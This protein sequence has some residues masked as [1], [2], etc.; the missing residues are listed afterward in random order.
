MVSQGN[1][2]LSPV[3]GIDGTVVGMLVMRAGAGAAVLPASF[4]GQGVQINDQASVVTPEPEY[5]LG[6]AH[7]LL[8]I[9]GIVVFAVVALVGTRIARGLLE[10]LGQLEK[11]VDLL[12]SGDTHVRFSAL[13]RTD[14]IGRIARS[15]AKIQE[16]LAELARLKAGRF[17]S[18]HGDLIKNLKSVWRELKFAAR[19]AFEL[20]SSDGRLVS[21]QLKT[22]WSNWM[23]NLG[24]PNRT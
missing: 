2:V 15:I 23:Q 6:A 21:Q 11:E 10:P 5:A 9:A 12:A 22:G 20:L 14:E 17:A 24:I 18:E 3:T 7:L 16:S 1:A 4:D 19:N 13:S 8:L